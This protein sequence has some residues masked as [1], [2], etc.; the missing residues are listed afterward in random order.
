M[1]KVRMVRSKSR[2]GI[3]CCIFEGT[4]ENE[5]EYLPEQALVSEQGRKYGTV[6]VEGGKAII[7]LILPRFSR[8]NNAQPFSWEDVESLPAIMSD[9]EMQ[10]AKVLGKVRGSKVKSVEV[11]VT[12][13]VSGNATQSKVLNLLN[14]ACLTSKRDNIKYI[15]PSRY[16]RYKEVV[17]SIIFR[18]PQYYVL[19]A[20]DKTEQQKREQLEKK[21][22]ETVPN[23]LLRVEI[24]MLERILHKLFGKK[25]RLSDIL[26]R[27]GISLLLMEYKRIFCE[28]IRS[29]RII[30]YLNYCV[31]HVFESL[32][33]TDDPISTIAKEHEMIPDK[34]VLY[35]ALKKWK[36]KK[37]ESIHN[38]RREVN[39]YTELYDLPQDVIK[40]IRDFRKAC[41]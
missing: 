22:S 40:T 33:E 38:L 21:E 10:L 12:Q 32:C 2:H 3:D 15:G 36:E 14:H 9:C 25:G 11:N 27:K 41:G 26:S 37:G 34:E 6:K 28:E 31:N 20:Y 8:N 30:P 4:F 23:G 5:I 13:E 16:C 19:K 35:R 18:K 1:K 39:K 29:K 17:N 24:I 7:N